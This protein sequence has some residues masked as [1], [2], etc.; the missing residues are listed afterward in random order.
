M[1]GIQGQWRTHELIE[2]FL[3]KAFM[4]LEG[5]CMESAMQ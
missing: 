5:V 1:L 3:K 2:I 4:S